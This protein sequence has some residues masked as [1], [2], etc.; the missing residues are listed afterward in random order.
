MTDRVITDVAGGVAEVR[1]NRPDKHNALDQAMFEGIVGAGR[2][3]IDRNDVRAV[4]L[5]GDG[6]SFCAGLDFASF[7]QSG[8]DLGSAFEKVPGDAADAAQ[9]TA[10]VWRRLPMPVIAAIH[11]AAF[12]GGLQVALGA[13]IRLA[14]PDARLSVMEIKWGLIPDMGITVTLKDV[15]GLDVAKE[16]IFTGRVV[17]GETAAALRLVTRTEADPLAAARELA[18]EIAGKSPDAVR[19][20]KRLFH[21]AWAIDEAKTLGEEA[22]AQQSLLGSPNQMEAVQSS[23]SKRPPNYRDPKSQ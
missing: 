16:L 12:G 23:F 19:H 11:G 6:P 17:D 10:M 14:A 21:T 4:V 20:A 8:Q 13:D 9:Y 3:L 5:Y 1:L 15:V 7:M 22:K 18:A 2:A